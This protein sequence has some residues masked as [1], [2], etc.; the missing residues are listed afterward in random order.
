MLKINCHTH[1]TSIATSSQSEDLTTGWYNNVDALRVS[2][3]SCICGNCECEHQQLAKPRDKS[4]PP[5]EQ[6]GSKNSCWVEQLA[7]LRGA[8]QTHSDW[9][10]IQICHSKHFLLRFLFFLI[11]FPCGRAAV[12][13]FACFAVSVHAVHTVLHETPWVLFEM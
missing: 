2:A 11:W 12:I 6:A 4:L 10:N 3:G 1:E 9:L 13:F 5:V 7:M 8:D